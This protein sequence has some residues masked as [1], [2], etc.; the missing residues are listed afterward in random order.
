ML[1]PIAYARI[2]RNI[3]WHLERQWFLDR[4]HLELNNHAKLADRYNLIPAS[5]LNMFSDLPWERFNVPQ[6]HPGTIFWDYSKWPTRYGAVLP[7]YWLTFSRSELNE[8][9]A[10][11][12]LRDAGN[13]AV[14]FADS[15]YK[16]PRQIANWKLPTT[17]H[18]FPVISGDNDDKRFNDTRGRIHGRVIGLKLKTSSHAKW[19]NAVDTGFPVLVN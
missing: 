12:I 4:L 6:E 3:I 10:I 15:R 13:V 16:S 8:D 9:T 18:G 14:V 1:S 7:N 2:A 17:W 19:Q 11:D 5:R